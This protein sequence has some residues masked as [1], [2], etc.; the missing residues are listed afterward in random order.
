MMA[1]VIFEL[2]NIG[3]LFS[4]VYMPFP[5]LFGR[6]MQKPYTELRTSS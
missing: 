2:R 4:F 1:I 5:Y 6:F 3:G